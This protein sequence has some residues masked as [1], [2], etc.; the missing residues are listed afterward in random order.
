[1]AQQLIDIS[2]NTYGFLK[3]IQ[4]SHMAKRRRSYWECEC[5]RC[6]RHITIRKD[7]FAY[8]YSKVKSCGCWHIEESRMRARKNRNKTSGKFESFSYSREDLDVNNNVIDNKLL[9]LIA[10]QNNSPLDFVYAIMHRADLNDNKALEYLKNSFDYKYSEDE[11]KEVIVQYHREN[12][13][14]NL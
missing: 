1:M 8:P 11:L 10:E 4:F 12:G 14:D 7:S 9:D 13:K 6:G 5:L 3:V 2:G